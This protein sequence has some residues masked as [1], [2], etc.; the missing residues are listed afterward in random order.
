MFLLNKILIFF[1]NCLFIL[2]FLFENQHQIKK[3]LI[4][5]NLVLEKYHIEIR[6]FFIFWKKCKFLWI[7]FKRIVLKSV[8][9]DCL[10]LPQ[11]I[12]FNFLIL[13]LK[14]FQWHEIG[15]FGRYRIYLN[16]NLYF[17]KY[18]KIILTEKIKD[19]SIK[20]IRWNYIK[21]Y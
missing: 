15:R 1:I 17:Y 12:F 18:K 4:F 2:I 19:L 20:S 6:N 21:L 7:F 10:L 11:S 14:I 5:L 3:I 9:F 8:V 16:N 13:V